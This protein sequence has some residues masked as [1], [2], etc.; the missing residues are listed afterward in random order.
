MAAQDILLTIIEE[1]FKSFYIE[2]RIIVDS[3]FLAFIFKTKITDD[4]IQ[5]LC[6]SRTFLPILNCPFKAPTLQCARPF[7]SRTSIHPQSSCYT[8]VE[9]MWPWWQASRCLIVS[10]CVTDTQIQWFCSADK[11]PSR[12][13]A[14]TAGPVNNLPT[15]WMYSYSVCSSQSSVTVCRCNPPLMWCTFCFCPFTSVHR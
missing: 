6:R 13:P 10:D 15:I 3:C 12:C 7:S 1:L 9:L 11:S 14:A 5:S 4:S 8:S 2:V